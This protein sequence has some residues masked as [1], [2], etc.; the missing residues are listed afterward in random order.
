MLYAAADP[1]DI[2]NVGPS[3]GPAQSYRGLGLV[4]RIYHAVRE[5][6]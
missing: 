4:S 3:W 2:R 1:V 6:F 5:Y